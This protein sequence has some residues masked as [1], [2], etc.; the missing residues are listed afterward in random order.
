[1][2]ERHADARGQLE[3]AVLRGIR[4][5]LD[6]TAAAHALQVALAELRSRIEATEPRPLEGRAR[7]P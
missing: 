4:G 6:E 2:R 1:M 5:A 7:G 3:R